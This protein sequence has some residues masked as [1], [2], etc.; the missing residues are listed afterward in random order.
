[1]HD[2]LDTRRAFRRR[3]LHECVVPVV[4][5]IDIFYRLEWF[6]L[7]TS[8]GHVALSGLFHLFPTF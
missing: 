7:H 2:F 3:V 6:E 1:M 4:L 8:W 5:F